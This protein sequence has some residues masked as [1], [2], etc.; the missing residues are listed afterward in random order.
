MTK[1]LAL[2]TGIYLMVGCWSGVSLPPAPPPDKAFTLLLRDRDTLQ[3][4]ANASVIAT[5]GEYVTWLIDR[6][7]GV[8]EGAYM[9]G[10]YTITIAQKGYKP[11]TLT[12]LVAV[13]VRKLVTGVSGPTLNVD[14]E[15]DR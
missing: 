6:A 3:P 10:E 2:L 14:L 15:P 1:Y 5:S 8:Y 4:V 11:Q 12:G 7:P 9:A 13:P